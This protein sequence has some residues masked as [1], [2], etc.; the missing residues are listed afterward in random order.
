MLSILLFPS[1]ISTC[2]AVLF[3]KELLPQASLKEEPSLTMV[4]R[5]NIE[6]ASYLH[7]LTLNDQPWLEY[8]NFDQGTNQ[9][10]LGTVDRLPAPSDAPKEQEAMGKKD[11]H[12]KG[13]IVPRTL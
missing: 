1:L 5:S 9:C 3:K 7:I 13:G 8:Y 4:N 6:C 2:S 11:L 12:S 10:K